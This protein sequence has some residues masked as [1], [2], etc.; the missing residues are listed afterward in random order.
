MKKIFSIMGNVLTVCLLLIPGKLEAQ[1]SFSPA[2]IQASGYP[3]GIERFDVNMSNSG[4]EPLNCTV[5]TYSTKIVGEGL[6]IAVEDAQRSCKQWIDIKPKTFRLEP[7]SDQRLMCTVNPPKGTAGGYYAIIS[8]LGVP[9]SFEDQDKTPG[10]KAGIRFRYQ[11]QTVV[12][13]TVRGANIKAIIEPGEPIIEPKKDGTGFSVQIPVRNLGNVH[14]QMTGKV[15][16]KSED[17]QTVD[18]F[19][20]ISGRGFVLPEHERL[21]KTEGFF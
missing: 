7:N 2:I 19:D 9:L 15:A 14:D 18:N 21:F 6:P 1:L 16:I 10:R 12:L 13:F 8:C 20:L 17:G 4:T 5:R 3:G 11:V